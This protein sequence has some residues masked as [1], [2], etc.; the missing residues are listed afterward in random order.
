MDVVNL[1]T[2]IVENHQIWAYIII[3]FG[4][5]IEGEVTAISAG[6]LTHLGVLSFPVALVFIF[7]GGLGKT[8]LGYALGQ[9]LHRRFNSNKFFMYVKKKVES[10][11]PRFKEKPFWSIFISKFIIGANHLVILYSGYEGVN[12]RKYLK[13]EIL[14][15]AIWAPTVLSLGY[16][17]SYTALQ[18][19]RDIWQFS[20]IVLILFILFVAFDKLAGILY[21]FFE[22]YKNGRKN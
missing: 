8:I 16:F 11:V 18:V 21:E 4:M 15:T 20:M 13:A 22:E 5:V 9:Y 12:Y 19:S 14:A 7:L 1:I 2:G 6:I 17:F 3:L 10:V